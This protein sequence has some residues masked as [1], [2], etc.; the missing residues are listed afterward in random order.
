M[1]SCLNTGYLKK[2]KYIDLILLKVFFFSHHDKLLCT[3]EHL[4]SL[5]G[6]YFLRN[7]L[8]I[9][10]RSEELQLRQNLLEAAGVQ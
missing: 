10:L 8:I 2:I 4:I 7:W 5:H 3:L 9:K 6:C 1:N